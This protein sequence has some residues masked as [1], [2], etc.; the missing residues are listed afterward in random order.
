[1]ARELREASAA[2][3]HVV[4]YGDDHHGD[5][6]DFDGRWCVIAPKGLFGS[7]GFDCANIFCNPE[8]DLVLSNFHRRLATVGEHSGI[9]VDTFRAWVFAWSGLSATWTTNSGGQ[10]LAARAILGEFGSLPG[11]A[12]PVN[13]RP[14]RV[15]HARCSAATQ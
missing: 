15:P 11:H 14:V 5:V 6:L 4:L 10:P 9:D 8:T 7:R 2:D 13:Y 12:V 3:K 1:V